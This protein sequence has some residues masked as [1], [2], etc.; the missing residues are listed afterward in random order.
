MLLND[1]DISRLLVYAQ[2]IE[3][4]NI[5]ELMQG[6][7]RTRFDESSHPKTKNRFYNQEFSMRNKDRVVNG[8]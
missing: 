7:K 1:M 2:Q 5:R 3:E 8:E 6:G 4:W